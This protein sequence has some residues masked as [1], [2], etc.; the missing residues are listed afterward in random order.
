MRTTSPVLALALL[1]LAAVGCGPAPNS[2]TLRDN[3]FSQVAA[4]HGVQKFEV[5]KN[6]VT[7]NF[8]GADYTCTV[9]GM[10]IAPYDDPRYTHIGSVDCEF[11]E[12]GEPIESFEH[13]RSVDID[14][15]AIVGAWDSQKKRWRFDLSFEAGE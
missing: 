6:V 10:D 13:L 5:K 12:N 7:F 15:Q 3:F 2:G 9:T 11:T 1:L 14:P 4:L 8:I